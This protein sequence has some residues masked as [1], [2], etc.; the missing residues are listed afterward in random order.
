[1]SL[2][3]KLRLQWFRVAR[4]LLAVAFVMG[5]T[6]FEATPAVGATQA[7]AKLPPDWSAGSWTAGPERYG[8][9]VET[10]VPITM[11]DG[12]VLK[13]D[14]AWPTE[15]TSG[16]RASG[17][18]P[19]ILEQTPY[20]HSVV[21]RPEEWSAAKN[22]A[23]GFR[24][25]DRITDH[26]RYYV[27]RGYIYVLAQVRGTAH[28]AGEYGFISEREQQDGLELVQWAASLK[29]SN[30]KLGLNGC[31]YTGLNQYFTAARLGKNSPVKAIAPAG[32]GAELY[33][34]PLFIGGAPTM[35]G[36]R[37]IISP[38]YSFVL[39]TVSAAQFTTETLANVMGGGDRAFNNVFWQTRR[40]ASAIEQI[41][42]NGI[43]AL[44]WSGWQDAYPTT[45]PEAY[46]MFQN[47]YAGRDIWKPM[48]PDTAATGRYQLI[49]APGTHCIG[50]RGGQRDEAHLKWFDTWVKGVDTGIDSTS[51][52]M[53]L[54][55]MH[56]GRWQDGAAYPLIAN[57]TTYFLGANDS[58]ATEAPVANGS[59]D[60]IR[61][62]Q[63][64]EESATLIYTTASLEQTAMLAGPMAATIFAAS[65]NANA[66]F[67]VELYDVA[68][69]G[70]AVK[71]TTGALTG[72]MR[73][74]DQARTWKDERGKLVRPYHG[75]QRATPL[76][77][78]EVTRF[79][80]QLQPR[81][82]EVRRGH[83]LSLQIKTQTEVSGCRSL[84]QDPENVAFYCVVPTIPQRRSLDGGVYTV[85]RSAKWPSHINL[86]VA[87]VGSSG[88][89]D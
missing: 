16:R 77:A 18:F 12:V 20:R 38:G 2:L 4:A 82:A 60:Q 80:I 61:Y 29:G 75:F 64:H 70:T 66:E 26:V 23:R 54:Y 43:P 25:E 30:G 40:A 89:A 33:R 81:L 13:A 8:V 27:S 52:P 59:K 21:S 35:T 84:D 58:L 24:P 53:H 42:R 19:L 57:Y 14:V 56:S 9:S 34:E 78:G 87:S 46:V 67:I 55:E 1:M 73:E 51:T 31:S 72:S 49:M 62:A 50:G 63:P 65:S 37:N 85:Y 44:I 71:L 7:N 10:D 41:V 74:L 48:D 32:M 88:S 69:E 6:L 36:L 39:G 15:I 5:V 28:S 11:S 3:F 17:S 47:A 22:S 45:A 86:P 76:K 83:R 79:D 68:P